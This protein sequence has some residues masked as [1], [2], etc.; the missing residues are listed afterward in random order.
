GGYDVTR[1]E[2]K[3]PEV[4]AIGPSRY[5]NT[6]AQVLTEPFD[7]SGANADIERRVDLE[8]PNT[9]VALAAPRVDAKVAVTEKITDREFRSVS[10]DVRDAD[11]KFRVEPSRVNLTIRG[12]VLKL[13]G[14][15]PRGLA[16]VD[17]KELM[18]GPHEVQ[19]QLDLPDGFQ[20][21][22]Q[23][24]DKLRLRLYREK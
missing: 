21:V 16:F 17:A 2:V 3:P 4:M 9:S 10:V 20:L 22:R 19:L 11:Y 6:M 15:D 23:S 1:I 5:V 18:P 24:P 7:I 12:P 8:N 14:L 13:Q